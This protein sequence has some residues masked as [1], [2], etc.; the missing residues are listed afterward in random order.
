MRMKHIVLLAVVSLCVLVGLNVVR[1]YQEVP[2]EEFQNAAGDATR[3][4]IVNIGW[5]AE[6]S[7]SRALKEVLYEENDSSAISEFVENIIVKRSSPGACSCM[8][9]LR[10]E[11][12]ADDHLIL[13]MTLH[14]GKA[15]RW[16]E[17]RLKGDARL[18]RKSRRFVAD[19]LAE[20]D[21]CPAD[22][23]EPAAQGATRR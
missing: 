18:S 16:N 7:G 8:G 2:W 19:W 1:R 13:K 11:F 17:S 15:F 10:F 5:V 21:I 12:Y 14:H 9:A 20:R 23:R 4:R 22:I 6:K 3:I